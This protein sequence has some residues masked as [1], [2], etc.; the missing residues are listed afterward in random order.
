MAPV[1]ALGASPHERVQAAIEN[2]VA[3][4]RP[5]QDALATFWDG[6][7]YVQCRRFE[8][9]SL[10]CEAG[11]KLMQPSLEQV[12]TTE[13][14]ARLESLGWRLEPA[15]GNFFQDFPREKPA[16]SVANQILVVL[17]DVYGADP[18]RLQSSTDWIAH[19][20]CPQRNGPSQNLAGSINDSR[21]MRSTSVHACAYR[22]APR[23]PKITS[24]ADLMEAYGQR[25]TLEIERLRINVHRDIFAV[26]D[27]SAGYVQCRP[28]TEPR[29]AILCEAQ[30]AYA[31][32]VLQHI[33]TPER[34]A[35][36]HVAGFTDPGRNENYVETFPLETSSGAEIAGVLLTVL[37]EA[38]DYR[39][40]PPMIFLTEKGRQ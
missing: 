31:W 29:L 34:I 22:P 1:R 6:N 39:G 23:P 32:P 4:D 27:S 8:G 30:S 35:R 28:E 26:F 15:F 12:L 18:Q 20:D 14:I 17:G 5:G 16:A 36:L 25:V 10:R 21:A 33:L 7:F 38:Y 19:E 3:L 37:Y 24:A 2:I 40:A 13:R 11:G 9:V